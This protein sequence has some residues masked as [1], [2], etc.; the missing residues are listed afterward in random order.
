MAEEVDLAVA[1]H[2]A[3]E[4]VALA[5][6]V[7]HESVDGL[8][9]YVDG[10][11]CLL[12]N[13]VVHDD[14]G[15]AEGQGLLLV[16]GHIQECNAQLFVDFL[17]LH[18]HVL[19]HLVVEGA[20]RLVEQQHLRRVDERTGYSH[21]LLLAAGQRLYVA[22]LVVGHVDHLEGLAN[23]LLDLVLRHLVEL[24][25]ESDVVVYVQMREKRVALENRVYG[26]FVRRDGVHLLSAYLYR[27]F[28]RSHES[29]KDSQKSGLAT[30]GR[31]E[32]GD[33]FTFLN[34]QIDIIQN[35]FVSEPLRD[36]VQ[37]DDEI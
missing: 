9:I 30:T 31:T 19:T 10:A 37:T 16:V 26:A 24:E 6:E 35:L 13:S 2:G 21:A 27:T 23:A 11:A 28:V 29:S 22:P 12:D 15:V 8:V 14:D 5:D 17:Q 18:L 33:E 4:D 3:V 36:M 32:N 7:G 20:Q 1:D 34:M 25:A